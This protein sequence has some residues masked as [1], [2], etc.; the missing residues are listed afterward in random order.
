M[1]GR[2]NGEICCA[3]S[4]CRPAQ[5]EGPGKRRGPLRCDSRRAA[6]SD[7]PEGR[8]D[9]SE[10][11]VTG[12]GSGSPQSS[13]RTASARIDH[14]VSF[15][16]AAFLPLPFACSYV[17]LMRLPSMRTCEPFLMVCRTYSERNGRKMQTRFRSVGEWIGS[18]LEVDHLGH[19]P[20]AGLA[21]ERRPRTPGRPDSLAF[22][23]GFWIVDAA[24]HPFRKEA[25]RIG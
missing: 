2:A 21:A 12:C 13:L 16:V 24:V 23:S 11:E 25:H 5:K 22:P 3:W 9:A 4:E 7:S 20:F 18:N 15:V 14:D 19:R 1:E 8:S 10:P 17:E 6:A